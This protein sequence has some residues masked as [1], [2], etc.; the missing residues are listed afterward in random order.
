MAGGDTDYYIIAP[1]HLID[2]KLETDP[3]AETERILVKNKSFK[4]AADIE[5]FKAF[6]EFNGYA[7]ELE[8]NVLLALDSD[9]K[10]FSAVACGNRK[11]KRPE[12][13]SFNMVF[14]GVAAT[15]Y[16]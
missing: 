10:S 14:S 12:S 4:T 16:G 13:I 2:P 6:Y 7:V 1:L 8:G 9:I 3:E 5:A 15:Y 11:L